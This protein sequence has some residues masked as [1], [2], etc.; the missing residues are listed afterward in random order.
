MEE[1]E[2]AEVAP[3]HSTQ[4]CLRSL[5]KLA[6]QLVCSRAA[7]RT[8]L[9]SGLGGVKFVKTTPPMTRFRDAKVCNNLATE[10]N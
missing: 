4:L 1:C 10:K 3:T 9:Q 7:M 5:R 6:L 2:V 8:M